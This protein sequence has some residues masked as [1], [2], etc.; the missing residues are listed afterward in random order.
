MIMRYKSARDFR[1]ALEERLRQRASQEGIPLLRLRKRVVFERCM[2][3]LQAEEPSPWVLKG[4]FALEL[5]LDN[6]A[7][8]TKDL[9]LSVNLGFFEGKL[10][11]L[12]Q[13]GGRLRAG[14]RRN[15]EDEFAFTVAE[16]TEEELP[17]QG[18]KSYRFTVE[19]RLDGRKFEMIKIDVGVGDPLIPPLDELKGS[20]LLAFA[21]IPVPVIRAT[22]LIQHFAEKIHALTR[23]YDDRINTRVKDLADLMLLIDY[24]L[25]EPP[26]VKTAVREIFT[27]RK[28]HEIPQQIETPPGTW[29]SS[30]TAM[31]AELN[32][33]QTTIEG[34]TSRLNDYWKT[35]VLLS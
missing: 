5:R 23:P 14:L 31:A 22:S 25:P 15:N 19:A 27:A 32:L 16:G 24:G 34:A 3:R 2:V 10:A 26:V 20:D 8:M 7:R 13:I 1:K 28:S 4:G 21:G 12:N 30:Y 29:A 33:A 9:D 11:S 35:F 6:S 18:V 17:T